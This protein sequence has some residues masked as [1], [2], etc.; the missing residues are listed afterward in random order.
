VGLLVLVAVQTSTTA[1]AAEPGA[2]P[3][4]QRTD[5]PEEPDLKGS[6]YTEYGEFDERDEEDE[7]TRFLQ[8]GRFFGVSLGGGLSGATGN[9]GSLYQGGFPS[10][11][12]KLHYWFD[13]NF[14]VE[15]ALNVNSHFFETQARG[16]VDT[17]L[18]RTGL[19]LKY[20]I[21]VFN[22]AAPISFA[23]PYLTLG[24]GSFQKTDRFQ[25]E[26]TVDND[27]SVGLTVGAGLEF[28][29]SPRRS[30]FYISGKASSVT[31]KDSQTADYEAE[32][33]PNLS[34]LFYTLT[35]GFLF[36]W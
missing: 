27:S 14:A 35:A 23:N 26:E 28:V 32:G 1:C 12:L 9:R 7:V 13:F 30:S 21:P 6:P 8:Y 22:L 34:G 4:T 3:S 11:E 17:T 19:D 10:F 36:T 18:L 31:F 5:Q 24:F 15:M 29:M 25:R 16:A 2:P 33:F 20:Y